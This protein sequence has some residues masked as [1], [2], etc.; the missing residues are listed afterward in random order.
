[1]RVCA[2]MHQLA[3]MG[4]SILRRSLHQV[5]VTQEIFV[6]GTSQ[7]LLILKQKL[8]EKASLMKVRKVELCL[9]CCVVSAYVKTP[10]GIDIWCG[11]SCPQ[12]SF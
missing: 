8:R 6:T 4:P 12:I 9:C 10:I 11:L 3:G 1:M 2:H 5:L 7:H